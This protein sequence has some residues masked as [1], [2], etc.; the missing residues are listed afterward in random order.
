[1]APALK[2]TRVF[3]KTCRYTSYT[4]YDKTVIVNALIEPPPQ[5]GVIQN[6][7]NLIR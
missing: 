6:A 4:L 1:M 3:K 5:L 2:L 7:Q